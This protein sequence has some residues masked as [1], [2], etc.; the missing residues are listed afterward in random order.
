MRPGAMIARVVL[1]LIAFGLLV[2]LPYEFRRMVARLE[3]LRD[4]GK[5]A[6]AQ[7]LEHHYQSGK[8]TTYYFTVSFTSQG[9]TVSQQTEVPCDVY[10]RYENAQTVPVET[11]PGE[12]N[13]Y[14]VGPIDDTRIEFAKRPFY[15]VGSLFTLI[16]MVFAIAFEFSL[17]TEKRLLGSGEAVMGQVKTIDRGKSVYASYE[18]PSRFG[19]GRGRSMVN[20][21]T[22]RVL[23]VNEQIQVIYDPDNDKKSMP[24]FAF[25]LYSVAD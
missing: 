24:M 9:H 21:D 13:N 17:A 12:P 11:M 15:I 23:Q 20:A 8:S 2:G 6:Q 4:S 18:F 10:G 14:E 3:T 5:V 7:I 22:A 1:W 25:Q 16:F 19:T